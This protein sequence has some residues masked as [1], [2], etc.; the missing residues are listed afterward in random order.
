MI[1]K[2]YGFLIYWFCQRDA[3]YNYLL[4]MYD[5]H[6]QTVYI[7]HANMSRIVLLSV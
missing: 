4:M 5:L 1:C 3:S 2:R 6:H 7:M